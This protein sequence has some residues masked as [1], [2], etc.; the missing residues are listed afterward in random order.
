MDPREEAFFRHLQ[1]LQE[2]NRE[3]RISSLNCMLAHHNH[4]MRTGSRG[5]LD[6]MVAQVMIYQRSTYAEK[7]TEVE[8]IINRSP[9]VSDD[10]LYK[11]FQLCKVPPPSPA[12][13]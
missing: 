2:L 10:D 1:V 13:R 12:S 4:Y 8:I 3:Q 11:L 6:A 5:H 9:L 7:L